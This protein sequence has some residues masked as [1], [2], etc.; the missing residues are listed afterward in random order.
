MSHSKLNS[1]AIIQF[2]WPHFSF[3][4]G[5]TVF[6]FSFFSSFFF[7]FFFLFAR[8]KLSSFVP[9]LSF[10][11]ALLFR[12]S[13]HAFTKLTRQGLL[14]QVLDLVEI[15]FLSLCFPSQFKRWVD[16]PNQPEN[17]KLETRS[18][19][20][21]R[22]ASSA[23]RGDTRTLDWLEYSSER[24]GYFLLLLQEVR[25]RNQRDVHQDLVS[26]TG[27]QPGKRAKDSTST[28]MDWATSRPTMTGDGRSA[29][30]P[31]WSDDLQCSWSLQLFI[32][33]ATTSKPLGGFV[34]TYLVSRHCLVVFPQL[35]FLSFRPSS[36]W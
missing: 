19:L 17:L 32:W 23:G 21:A 4:F 6:S 10:L 12:V 36:F 20:A 35:F 8:Q 18:S 5:D 30:N 26:R 14:Q 15:C 27:K 2:N 11:S 29:E 9:Q 28:S 16:W 13:R 1:I 31:H 22:T 3:S 7:S 34:V 24:A 33:V 25:Q